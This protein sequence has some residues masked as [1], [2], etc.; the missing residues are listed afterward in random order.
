MVPP[1]ETTPTKHVRQVAMMSTSGRNT[2]RNSAGAAK[3]GA[4]SSFS[5]EMDTYLANKPACIVEVFDITGRPILLNSPFIPG[6][7]TILSYGVKGGLIWYVPETGQML[8]R[9]GKCAD[10]SHAY[11]CC[12]INTIPSKS[13]PDGRCG[14]RLYPPMPHTNHTEPVHGPDCRTLFFSCLFRGFIAFY[15]KKLTNHQLKLLEDFFHMAV[16]HRK[17]KKRLFSSWNSTLGNVLS[18][19]SP[20][21]EELRR[22]PEWPTV[23]PLMA[24]PVATVDAALERT[25]HEFLVR[26]GDLAEALNLEVRIPFQE[27]RGEP[28]PDRDLPYSLRSPKLPGKFYFSLFIV[29]YPANYLLFVRE[30]LNCRTLICSVH[31]IYPISF[32]QIVSWSS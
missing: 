31:L 4:G 27:L 29:F 21:S 16:F 23:V 11:M 18:W 15:R 26:Y 28:L 22:S 19:G 25:C 7:R 10:G 13:R 20:F 2:K 3:S 8:M 17:V 30:V 32:F 1:P 9:E 24:H 12:T 5:A 6:C 14:G